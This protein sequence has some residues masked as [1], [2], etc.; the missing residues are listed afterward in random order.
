MRAG[1]RLHVRK[2]FFAA[3]AGEIGVVGPMVW[4]ADLSVGFAVM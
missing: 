4:A 1:V 3:I 2:W